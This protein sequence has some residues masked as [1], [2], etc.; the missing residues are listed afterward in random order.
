MGGVTDFLMDFQSPRDPDDLLG[1]VEPGDAVAR[2]DLDDLDAV[3][4]RFGYATG[5]DAVGAF[6]AYL[7][8]M[9]RDG[10]ASQHCGGDAFLVVLRGRHLRRAT[11]IVD[12][13]MRRWH[14]TAPVATFSAG[15]AVCRRGEFPT[16]T[17]A[18]AERALDRSKGHGGDLQMTE[19][20]LDDDR[21]GASPRPL[22]RVGSSAPL[23]V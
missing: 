18:R 11:S 6:S 20:D 22:H 15:T 2:F 10:D 14:T 9:L 19:D 16:S 4:E 21:G 13:L 17:L 3:N 23:R 5:D 7:H 8:G 12:R 1:S